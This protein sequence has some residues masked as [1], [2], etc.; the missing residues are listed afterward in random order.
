MWSRLE[1]WQLPQLSRLAKID[2]ERVESLLN[3]LWHQYPGLF[4]ELAIAAVDQEML[5][6]DDC[7][8]LL[9]LPAWAIEEKLSKFRRAAVSVE[10]A[11]V[12]DASTKSVARLASGQIAVWEVVREYRKLG[13]LEGLRDSFPTV[14][15]GELAAALRYAQE[16]GAEIE[17]MIREYEEVLAMKRASYPFAS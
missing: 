13:S 8:S 2:P 6:V 9:N 15:E 17:G 14:S 11:V 12:R 3:T 5:S 7:C 10:C 16:N 1:P 4:D